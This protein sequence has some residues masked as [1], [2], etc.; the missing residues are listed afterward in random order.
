MN[1]DDP[2]E[3]TV[4]G[5][6]F[7][8]AVTGAP[9]AMGLRN[10]PSPPGYR[11]LGL[12][13]EGGMGTVYRAEQ[14]HP[15][16]VVALKVI[17]AGVVTPD[18]LRR[19]EQEAEALGR[20][21]HPALAH[22]YE[23]GT[24]DS[25]AGPQ[26][27]FAMELVE[28]STLTEYARRRQLSPRDRLTLMAKICDGV[29]HAH[30]RGII[31]RDLKPGNILVDDSGQ[32]KVLD[33]GVARVTDAESQVTRQTD[34]GQLVGTLPYMSPEQVLAD[35][36]ELDTRSDVY[37]LGVVL[38]ELLTG[39]LPYD[40]S[41]KRLPEAVQ[42][43]REEDP[44]ALSSIDRIYRGDVDTIVTKALEKDKTRRYASA[45]DLAADIRRHLTDEPILARPATTAYQLR[46][47]ARR[48]RALVTGVAAVF[49]VLVAG[50]VVSSW[51][52]VRATR[53]EQ[54]ARSIN[55][56][57]RF[58][59]LAQ[60]SAEA[61][62]GSGGKADPNITVRTVLDR[63]AAR[64]GDT[65]TGR[66]EVR[67]AIEST[68]GKTYE[69]LGLYPEA[70]RHFQLALELYRRTAGPDHPDTLR[71]GRELGGLLRAQGQ[72]AEAEDLLAATVDA[73]RRALG[74]RNVDTLEATEALATVLTHRAKF[75]D[76]EPLLQ[77]AL[78]TSRQLLGSDHATTTRVTMGLAGLYFRQGKTTEAEPL[79]LSAIE[80][81]RRTLGPDHPSTL[82]LMGNLGVLY[83]SQRRYD[84]A[85]PVML[86]VLDARRRAFGDE[87]VDTL[88]VMNNLGVVYAALGREEEAEALYRQALAGTRKTLGP[89]HPRALGLMHNLGVLLAGTPEPA[90]AEALL[91]EA[92]GARDRVLGLEHPETM[93]S[94][95]VLGELYARSGDVARAEPLL[96]R[97]LD[98]RRNVFGADHAATAS[99]AVSLADLRFRQARHDEAEALAR[100]AAPILAEHAPAQFQTYRA[101]A[102][103]GLSLCELGRC[104]EGEPALLAAYDGMA[105]TIATS[106]DRLRLAEAAD[107]ISRMYSAAGRPDAA[108]EW[109]RRGGKDAPPAAGAPR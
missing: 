50:I 101:E 33:F 62:V 92:R 46:K 34:V 60:A 58:D 64:I 106:L 82:G 16:R 85:V 55:D 72:L 20:L 51:L 9:E 79:L 75:A 27:Y 103:L 73:S 30:Q 45:A 10:V 7:G 100:S 78:A 6:S 59:L 108:G 26:P 53:A 3:I 67:A 40:V 23:A 15:R 25:G 70:Q 2:G 8:D 57:L 48:H 87:H 74:R 36:L 28:G 19:F 32:P 49:V 105:T 18:L 86:E 44:V 39:R 77:E 63:A 104:Q 5:G 37:A 38:Y 31:H 43:I 76:A 12:I 84:E 94:A 22:V 42:T 56:F 97:T 89:E 41:R 52:A 21:Q 90:E 61:Q 80:A 11:I 109:R 99:A 54:T 98:G 95:Q 35:P 91:S 81:R 4:G 17:R 13:G 102:L 14:Q 69:G 65:F 96:T 71:L 88:N 93:H 24:A 68:I 1:A 66:P 83:E 29:H 107:R 47:F